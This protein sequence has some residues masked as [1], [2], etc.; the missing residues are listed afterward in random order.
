MDNTMDHPGV[1]CDKCNKTIKGYRYKCLE[2]DDYD[3]CQSCESDYHSGHVLCRFTGVVTVISL[4][5]IYKNWF[6]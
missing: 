6:A 3:L 5:L 2:C 1:S 4:F